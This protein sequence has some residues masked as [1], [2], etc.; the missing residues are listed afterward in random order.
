MYCGD[1]VEDVEDVEDVRTMLKIRI[2]CPPVPV[3][4]TRMTLI[5]MG[6]IKYRS[7]T[8]EVYERRAWTVP[9]RG[10]LGK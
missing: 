4:I 2:I 6:Y 7:H 1:N 9:L 8:Q 5:F 10:C 3:Y